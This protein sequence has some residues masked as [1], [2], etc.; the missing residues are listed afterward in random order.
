[1]LN[2]FSIIKLSRCSNVLFTSS[3]KRIVLTPLNYVLFTTSNFSTEAVI[4]TNSTIDK[5]RPVLKVRDILLNKPKS[6]FT[7]NEASSVADG[8]SHLGRII[9]NKTEIKTL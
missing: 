8:I 3:H 1:M 7:I 4:S 6:T 9:I 5:S 2:N